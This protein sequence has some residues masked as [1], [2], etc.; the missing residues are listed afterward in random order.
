MLTQ[1]VINENTGLCKETISSTKTDLSTQY[2]C[3]CQTRALANK[4]RVFINTNTVS[5]NANTDI[6]TDIEFCQ[7]RSLSTPKIVTINT[8]TGSMDRKTGLCQYKHWSLSHK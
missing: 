7:H 5:V 4:T 3:L 6:D 2:N 8:N 1:S